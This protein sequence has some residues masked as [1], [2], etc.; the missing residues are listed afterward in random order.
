[1]I[2]MDFTRIKL[3]TLLVAIARKV[4]IESNAFGF[5]SDFVKDSVKYASQSITH[6]KI[7][8]RDSGGTRETTQV[9]KFTMIL[10]RTSLSI[11][12]L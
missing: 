9:D 5:A 7:A 12:V 8:R 4:S 2:A 1:M 11:S 3:F 6:G 10:Q